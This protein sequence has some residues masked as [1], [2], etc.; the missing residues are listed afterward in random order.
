MSIKPTIINNLI[1]NRAGK[2]RHGHAPQLIVMHVQQGYNDLPSF[3]AVSGDD[4]TIWC[5]RDGTLVR[6]IFDSDSAWTNGE[7]TA[8]DMTHP[9]IAR[10]VN[11]GVKNTNDY[12]YTIEHQGFDYEGFT[13][14]QV[15]ATSQMVAFWCQQ[16]GW[17]PYDRVVGHMQVGPH[18]Q[19]PGPKFPYE[20]VKAR[21]KQ[22]LEADKAGS[23]T[24]PVVTIRVING[25]RL[26]HG[27]LDYWSKFVSDG[28]PHPLGFPISNEF[29]Y[30]DV[31][32]KKYV[33]QAFERAVLGYDSTQADPRYRVQGLL[34]GADWLRQHG[35]GK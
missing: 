34:I 12:S 28:V 26:G 7:V 31:T 14:A 23:T 16:E 18:K 24:P 1:P 35:L 19:C 4:S 22:L 8:P 17:D 15:E 21:A 2:G 9:I 25:F 5:K 3:F 10:L 27:M 11:A 32:G 20:R 6:L 29:D 33:A 13:E 30:T